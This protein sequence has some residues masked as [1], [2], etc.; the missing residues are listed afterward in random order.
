[1]TTVCFKEKGSDPAICG[2]HRTPLI[3]C[4]DL[5]D[6]SAP[7]LGVIT[8]LKCPASG[9]IVLDERGL[10]EQIPAPGAIPKRSPDSRIFESMVSFPASS[11]LDSKLGEIQR[12]TIESLGARLDRI[13]ILPAVVLSL[14][15]LD[16]DSLDATDQ[17]IDLVSSDPTLALRLLDLANVRNRGKGGID[18]IPKAV[19]VVGTKPFASLVLALSVVEVFVPR[20]PGQCNLW[21]H[22]IQTSL[23][24]RRLATLRPD[25]GIDPEASFLTGLLHD[26]GRFVIF[27]YRPQENNLLEDEHPNDPTALIEAE[28]RICGFDHATLGGEICD[29]WHLPGKVC[30][31]VRLHHI[32]GEAKSRIPREVAD[33]VRMVQLA[34]S[35]SFGLLRDPLASSLSHAERKALIEASLSALP[36]SERVLSADRLAEELV[37]IEFDSRAAASLINIPYPG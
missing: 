17:I 37:D 31:A 8:C 34:D 9:R 27:E 30:E 7:G 19:A 21:I 36:S 18:S 6:P 5:V 2:V 20:T 12:R 22:S 32:Y 33:L 29:R 35:F 11:V 4:E 13:A 3:A 25:L 23:T 16:L 10:R 1:M 26:I 14:A 28:R 24:A 15:A